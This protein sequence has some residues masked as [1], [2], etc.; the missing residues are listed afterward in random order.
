[1]DSSLSILS[2]FPAD[3]RSK[4]AEDVAHDRVL[5]GHLAGGVGVD[6]GWR[7]SG[8]DELERLEIEIESDAFLRRLLLDKR[9]RLQVFVRLL[10]LKGLRDRETVRSVEE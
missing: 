5:S 1:M 7:C 3:P 2:G 6:E 9:R 4:L 10:D 8:G